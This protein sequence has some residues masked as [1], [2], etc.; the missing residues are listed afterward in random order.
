MI[1]IASFM[2]AGGRMI[3]SERIQ[4][5]NDNMAKS[6][7]HE[8]YELYY[9]EYGKRY[10]MVD[11]S[12]YSLNS[13]EFIIFPPYSMH[14]SYGDNDVP[15][16]RL[17]VYFTP[18]TVMVPEVLH[19]FS[20]SAGVYRF[21]TKTSQSVHFLLKEIL[22]EQEDAEGYHFDAM[23]ML[24]NQILIKT[25]RRSDETAAPENQSRIT[26]ILHYLHNHYSEN[27]TLEDLAS[28][29]YISPYYL[30]REFK[31]YTNSTIIQYINNI[32]IIHAQ[33]LFMETNRTITDISKEVGFSNVTHFNRVF[34]SII[35]M[36]PSK[37]RK[38]HA[39]QKEQG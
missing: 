23:K 33:R 17:L 3:A 18:E 38:Q 12:I 34:K 29:F 14:H 13:G 5:V 19:I 37:S 7:Y 16:K 2:M 26:E 31:R 24:L 9:L 4:G 6:H 20:Q 15:F 11:D 10:H 28:R 27:I 1:D 30:C 36:S 8:Y 35:G 25:A 22:K 32:R 21:D 39:D